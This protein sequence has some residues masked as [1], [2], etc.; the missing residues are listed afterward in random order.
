LLS[1]KGLDSNKLIDEN[2]IR[3]LVFSLANNKDDLSA[4]TDEN[5]FIKI[6]PKGSDIFYSVSLIL[7]SSGI[8]K[9]S[10]KK[11]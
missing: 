6:S 2:N 10:E 8:S 5:G 1:I 3:Y 9:D 4:G 11:K 7:E